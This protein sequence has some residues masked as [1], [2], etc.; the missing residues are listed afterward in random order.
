MM[1]FRNGLP[2]LLAALWLAGCS[3]PE[4]EW[5]KAQQDGSEDALLSYIQQY[6]ESPQAAEARR[7]I[8]EMSIAADWQLAESA[9]TPEA[10]ELFLEKHPDSVFAA[11]ASSRAA[12]LRA[13]AGWEALRD[14][15]DVPALEVFAA[16]FA[17]AP[18]AELARARLAELAAPP[19][20]A[21]ATAPPAPRA[22][23][24]PAPR[25]P[26]AA[27][28]RAPSAPAAGASHRVQFGAYAAQATANA[29]R[30]RLARRLAGVLGGTALEVQ[31]AGGMHRIVTT[32]VSE[33]QAR[34]LCASAKAAGA[35]CFVRSR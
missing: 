11:V 22:Q 3:N 30:E 4:T 5:Q 1:L 25:A 8:V 29:E 34:E 18:E 10:Y 15:T 21:P 13:R 17:D 14:S 24:A 27:A 32:A 20:P 12:G 9:G 28:P 26:A 16:Q 35:E 7:M 23:A 19:A 31:A 6:P 33:R 2:V